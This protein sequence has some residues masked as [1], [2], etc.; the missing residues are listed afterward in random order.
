MQTFIENESIKNK[1]NFIAKGLTYFARSTYGS[2]ERRAGLDLFLAVCGG[3]LFLGEALL[4]WWT[5]SQT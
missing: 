5:V 2:E 1:F 3:L 4:W